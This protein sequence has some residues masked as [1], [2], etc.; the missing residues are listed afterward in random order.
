MTPLAK[1]KWA[2]LDRK[3]QERILQNVWCGHCEAGTTI[4]NFIGEV[5]N[6]CLLLRGQCQTCG[7]D[8]ARYLEN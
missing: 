6:D 2:A 1:Q 5:R 7:K 3:L 8:V 4:V